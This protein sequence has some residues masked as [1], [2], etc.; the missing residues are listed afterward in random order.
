MNI[1][2]LIEYLYFYI[3]SF[4]KYILV[5]GSVLNNLI[6]HFYLDWFHDG[7]TI[8]DTNYKPNTFINYNETKVDIDSFNQI[9]C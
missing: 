3:Y 6:I 8:N 1:Y 7:D 4:F 2:Y 9:I 5:E